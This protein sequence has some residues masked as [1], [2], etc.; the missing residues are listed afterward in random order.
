MGMFAYNAV[1]LEEIMNTGLVSI[2]VPIYKSEK[3]LDECIRSIV[4]QTYSNLEILL[5]DDGSPDKSP[6]ICD[7]WAAKDSRIHV[8]HKMN[9][10]SGMARNTGMEHATGEYIC[11]FDSDDFIEEDMIAKMQNAIEEK[12]CDICVCGYSVDF[13]NNLSEEES[14]STVVPW[15]K[16][17]SN[18]S[19]E[20][21]EKN[22]GICGY[23]WNKMYRLQFLRSFDLLFDEKISLYEDLIFNSSAF[24]NGA[25]VCFI[26]NV[27]YHYIQRQRESLGVKYYDNLF[28]LRLKAINAKRDI[29]K[30]WKVPEEQIETICSNNFIDAIWGTIKNIKKARFSTK[31]KKQRIKKFFK[32]E[33]IKTKLKKIKPKDKKR[34][35]KRY[36]LRF[37]STGILLRVVR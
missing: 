18:L 6:Q 33:G 2:V 31:K 5:V 24:C 22:L 23:V 16:E 9:A 3:Y 37:L 25:K 10:G 34:K 7:A 29:L 32:E 1:K 17:S 13:Y 26:D 15:E 35:I 11:F 36:M 12:E 20:E 14:S 8:I 28:S 19:V 4:E 27:G 30:V 21:Y